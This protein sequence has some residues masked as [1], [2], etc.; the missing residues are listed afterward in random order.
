LFAPSSPSLP[1]AQIICA[2]RYSARAYQNPSAFSIVRAAESP[3][4]EDRRDLRS[5]SQGIS[6]GNPWSPEHPLDPPAPPE[7]DQ[8]HARDAGVLGDGFYDRPERHLQRPLDVGRDLGDGGALGCGCGAHGRPADSKLDADRAQARQ[9][10]GPALADPGGDPACVLHAC[11]RR[12]LEVEGDQRLTRRDQRRAGAG[13]QP[14]R[15]EVRP[16]LAALQPRPKPAHPAAA[17]IRP[18]APLRQL[19]VEQHGHP[20][21]ADLVRKYQR[22]RAGGAALG[23]VEVDDRRHVQRP[24][25]RMLAPLGSPRAAHDVDAL[26]G[27]PRPRE[28]GYR[29]LALRARQREH[30]AVVVAV[31][32]DI[33]QPYGRRG[34]K[35]MSD[36]VDDATVTPLGRVGHGE[37][38]RGGRG[39]HGGRR[40]LRACQKLDS[41]VPPE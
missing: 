19:A 18:R 24:Y 28:H 29:E 12:Q 15:P 22:L 32:V 40:S 13:M 3:P 38:G 16:Q 9:P 11:R 2:T 21:L 41:I 35:G 31:G 17:Q 25:V 7:P 37:Q 20:Q 6:A 8:L 33:E 26:D 1:F 23:C 10:F 36:R 5:A 27:N 14:L 4:I 34:G 30:R 39:C